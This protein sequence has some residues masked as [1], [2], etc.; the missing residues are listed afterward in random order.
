MLQGL[1]G[2]PRLKQIAPALCQPSTLL[3]RTAQDSSSMVTSDHWCAVFPRGE[4]KSRTATKR[5]NRGSR[6]TSRGCQRQETLYHTCSTWFIYS[7]LLK[8]SHSY[9]ERATMHETFR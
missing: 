3:R 2:D 8:S 5:K 6:V 9:I 7:C 4:R 1:R